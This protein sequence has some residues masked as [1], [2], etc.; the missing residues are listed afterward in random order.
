MD[1]KL[2]MYDREVGCRDRGQAKVKWLDL[3]SL[4][5]PSIPYSFS[6]ITSSRLTLLRT[7]NELLNSYKLVALLLFDS[8]VSMIFLKE[9]KQLIGRK[10]NDQLMYKPTK[11]TFLGR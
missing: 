8:S 5:L 10:L 11:E 3:A 1:I 6:Q 4:Y 9:F 7:I 2:T